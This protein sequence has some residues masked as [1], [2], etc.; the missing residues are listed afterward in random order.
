MKIK[1][2][3]N[4]IVESFIK[5]IVLGLFSIL[6]IVGLGVLAMCIAH[7][8][9]VFTYSTMGIFA[10]WILGASIKRISCNEKLL[11]ITLRVY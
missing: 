11:I 6:F 2:I 5:P 7:N 9:P 3:L 1:I 10:L 4:T 8:F